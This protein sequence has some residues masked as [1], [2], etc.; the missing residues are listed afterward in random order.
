MSG[1]PY[2]Y[3]MP[4]QYIAFETAN[5]IKMVVIGL[6]TTNDMPTKYEIIL[7][8]DGT[9]AEGNSNIKVTSSDLAFAT[10]MPSL[11]GYATEEWVNTQGFLKEH[12][13]ISNLATKD[14]VALKANQSDVD[15]EV[16][17]LNERIAAITVPTKVSELEN[18][19]QYQTSS[20]VDARIQAVVGAAPEALDT[21]EEIANKLADNDD[22]VAALTTQIAE[23]ATTEALNAE[24]GARTAKDTEIEAEL[25]NKVAY[26]DVTT[27]ENPNRKAIVLNNHDTLLGNT[28]SGSAVNIAMVSKWD[29]VD[30][31]ST[32]VSINLNG[33]DE[34]PTYNDDAELALR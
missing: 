33:K 2:Y 21:L 23:K 17:A 1:N 4:I 14:E 15:F 10:D 32:Q 9:I 25:A 30:L 29:K 6:D 26:T 28:T 31:G 8:L 12:Q 34:R 5:Q 7:N 19:A 27:E 3:R 18:D 11:D 22:V 24:I 13:D 16:N 20:E